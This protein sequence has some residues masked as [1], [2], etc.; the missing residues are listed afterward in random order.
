MADY[1]Y[2][3]H[4]ICDSYLSTLR[5][6][7]LEVPSFEEASSSQNI[8]ELDQSFLSP[9]GENS[10]YLWQP[11]SYRLHIQELERDTVSSPPAPPV[12]SCTSSQTTAPPVD[13]VA[14]NP[15]NEGVT[16]AR[17]WL[18]G[19][20]HSPA[21]APAT[22]SLVSSPPQ[23]TS[24]PA[25]WDRI[26]QRGYNPGSKQCNFKR[27]E[28]IHF[29]TKDHPGINLGDALHKN[30]AHLRGKSEPVLQGVSGSI[31]CRL[32]FP[33]Y[34]DNIGPCQIHAQDWTKARKPIRRS[35]L[36][37]EVAKKVDR[38]LT[39][40]NRIT[41]DGTVQDCWRVGHG[42]MRL[43]NMF[44]VSLE[45]VSKGS[46]QPEIWVATVPQVPTHVDGH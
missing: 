36:A 4:E 44:L 34:P 29:H 9:S 37:Y 25:N 42:F 2:D 32:L 28:P 39:L 12:I 45:S 23:A 33:G 8:S 3:P 30:F 18:T 10:Q 27:L 43:D 40:L 1:A 35:K 24:F 26:P 13:N 14:R 7:G 20:V 15:R 11:P 22:P 21:I 6:F 41:P 31:S 38:Y 17:S 46:F 5:Y 16:E 19:D